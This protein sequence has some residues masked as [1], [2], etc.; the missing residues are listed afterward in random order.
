MTAN[1]R[2]R[3]VAQANGHATYRHEVVDYWPACT[4]CGTPIRRNVDGPPRP[5][6]GKPT[7]GLWRACDCPDV[8]WT[9]RYRSDDRPSDG[10]AKVAVEVAEE[11]RS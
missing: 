2:H 8:L 10:W 9:I 6:D 11:E 5:Y 7:P 3:A 1:E 4:A